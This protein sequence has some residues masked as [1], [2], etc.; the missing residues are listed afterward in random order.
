MALNKQFTKPL[1]ASTVAISLFKTAL[2][3]FQDICL[4]VLCLPSYHLAL[5]LE[6]WAVPSSLLACNSTP[7]YH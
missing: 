7:R 6:L 3:L 1:E 5:G 2:L 4:N